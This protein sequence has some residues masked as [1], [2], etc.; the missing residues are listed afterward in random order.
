MKR[1]RVLAA[2]VGVIA[3]AAMTLGAGTASAE[4]IADS[5]KF[6]QSATLTGGKLV[7]EIANKT[8]WTAGCT[9]SVYEAK[10]LP[11]LVEWST[12]ATAWINGTG[13]YD[14]LAGVGA[15]VKARK[16]LNDEMRTPFVAAGETGVA[17]WDS[18]RSN[19]EY[20]VS[21]SC[22]T[23]SQTGDEIFAYS[24]FKVAGTGAGSG[25]SGSLGNLGLGSLTR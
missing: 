11:L 10:E 25:G 18:R 13:S 23:N 16:V 14:D 1:L 17:T 4:I 6:K 3:A 20:A 24:S 8:P 15:R 7:I 9:F 5:S 21:M 12:A 2:T 19:S 22:A